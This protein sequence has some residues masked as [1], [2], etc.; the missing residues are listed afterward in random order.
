MV[1]NGK[2][3]S[4]PQEDGDDQCTERQS[5]NTGKA[6][7]RIACCTSA[8]LI[9]RRSCVWR[10]SQIRTSRGPSNAIL[11][12]RRFANTRNGLRTVGWGK[13]R[14]V[15]PLEVPLFPVSR[16]PNR[17]QDHILVRVHTAP[18]ASAISRVRLEVGCPNPV[19]RTSKHVRREVSSSV[20]RNPPRVILA[21]LLRDATSHQAS[22]FL[23][24]KADLHPMV[25]LPLMRVGLGLGAT[26][27]R[28]RLA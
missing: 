15:A 2:E 24:A 19:S 3:V 8:K 25:S 6:C 14:V 21:R 4:R 10:N 27:R 28:T 7:A 1:K 9:A 12:G 16:T 11:S 23:A 20:R 26:L 17:S 18:I 5:S 13:Q 22:E